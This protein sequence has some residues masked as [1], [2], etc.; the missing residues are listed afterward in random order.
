MLWLK[1]PKRDLRSNIDTLVTIGTP[2]R[3]DYQF[4]QSKIGEHFNVFSRK[5]KVQP[6]GGMTFDLPG[7]IIPGFIPASRQV[8][9]PGVKNLDATSE[10]GSHRELWTKTGTWNNIVAP[11]IKK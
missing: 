6:A 5:D 11:E 7:T 3:S 9:L 4:N 1:P 2:I 8:N 10:A